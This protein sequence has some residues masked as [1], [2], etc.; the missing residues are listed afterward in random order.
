MRQQRKPVAHRSTRMNVLIKVAVTRPEYVKAP[1]VFEQA[2]QKGL[3]CVCVPHK[4]AEC[5]EAIRDQKA[6]HLVLGPDPYREHIYDALPCGGVLARFGVGFDGVR[7]ERATACGLY[8][9]NTPG[10]LDI[11]VAEHTMGLIA[12]AARRTPFLNQTTRRGDW[13]PTVGMEL[14][15]KCLAVIGCGPIGC[16]VARIASLGYGM[17]VMGCEVRQVDVE[18]LKRDYGFEQIVFDFAEAVSDADF[19]SLHIPNTAATRR[20]MDRERLARLRHDA[21]LINTSRGAV[22]DEVALF[23]ALR[24]RVIG[25]AALDVFEREPY[26]PV[27]ADKNMCGMDNVIMTPH[28][29]S[30]TAEAC[31]RMA[32]RALENIQLAI[33][34]RFAE[35]NILNR[36][37]LAHEK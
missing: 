15:G 26:A 16:R 6:R 3:E 29:G 25:G 31:R 32:T 5:A 10:V 37:V 30:A 21:W 11:S 33:E 36:E 12:A 20:Y 7:L 13:L 23:D 9:T 4:D 28:V 27:H 19:V 1:R 8:C 22:V 35:M 18:I 17:R 14:A 24:D 34:G 2:I